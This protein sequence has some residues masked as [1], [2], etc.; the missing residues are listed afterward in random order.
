MSV[1]SFHFFNTFLIAFLI[2]QFCTQAPSYQKFMNS[3]FLHSFVAFLQF[4]VLWKF[5]EFSI[6]YTIYP[7][8]FLFTVLYLIPWSSPPNMCS[9]I[10][11]PMKIKPISHFHSSCALLFTQ[12]TVLSIP[13]V[14]WTPQINLQPRVEVRNSNTSCSLSSV[15]WTCI[16][17][18]KHAHKC[19]AIFSADTEFSVL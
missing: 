2:S 10:Y 7:P 5:K 8:R 12:Y 17:T 4:S 18:H 16:H 13:Q 15:H 19:I 3:F 14:L 1:A 11:T 6:S 9:H